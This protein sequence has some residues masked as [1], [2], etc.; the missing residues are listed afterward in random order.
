MKSSFFKLILFFGILL[1]ASC[2]T[3]KKIST[4]P[5]TSTFI[6]S[7]VGENR[8]NGLTTWVQKRFEDGT[9]TIFFITIKNNEV[10]RHVES[11]RWWIENGKFY[12]ISPKAMKE[13]DI[14]EYVI[15]SKDEI[16]FKSTSVDYQFTDRRVEE[17]YPDILIIQ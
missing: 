3:T 12:E 17:N 8:I 4:H 6:G 2:S 11:G 16:F 9:Y 13:P 15:K 5:D 10:S 1:C 7:W 14:Y